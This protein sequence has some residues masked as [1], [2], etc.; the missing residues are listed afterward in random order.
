MQAAERWVR[1]VLRRVECQLKA[2][3][4]VLFEQPDLSIDAA[5]KMI[6]ARGH[7]KLDSAKCAVQ[8]Y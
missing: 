2:E 3:K 6:E 7:W 5:G 4:A 8:S 1:T